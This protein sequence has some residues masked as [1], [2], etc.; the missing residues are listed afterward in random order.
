MPS[1]TRWLAASLLA[2]VAAGLA[3]GEATLP[4][5]PFLPGRVTFPTE[6]AAGV[7]RTWGHRTWSRTVRGRPARAPFD[8]YTAL[9]DAPDITAAAARFRDLARHEVRALGED[10]YEADDGDGSRGQYRILVRAARR[11]VMLSWG[12]HS[13]GLI[14]TIRGSALTEL[15][16][17]PRGEDVAQELT[18]H[19]LIE[20]RVAAALARMLLVLFGGIADRRLREAFASAGQVAEWATA[21]PAEFCQWLGRAPMPPERRARVAG[22]VRGCGE[23]S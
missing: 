10:W 22:L 7:E 5:P 3:V 2:L 1:V 20:S 15:S 6:I 18:A 14:G 19:V 21:Q 4:W 23:P 8:L 9:V 17:E 11:R 12:E 16:L 13:S